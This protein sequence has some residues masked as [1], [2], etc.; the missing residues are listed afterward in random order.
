MKYFEKYPEITALLKGADHVDVKIVEG[1]ASLREFI[2]AMLSYYPWWIVSLYYVRAVFVRLLGMRQPGRPDEL[3]RLKPEDISMT[4][5][6]H[7]AFFIVHLAREEEYWIAETPEDKHLQAHFGIVVEPVN[8]NLNRFHVVT[9][10]HYKHWTG[11][12]Y[13]NTIRPFHHLVVRRM[14]RAGATPS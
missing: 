14:A 8:H 4:A 9:I 11:P 13:F 3:P 12:V 10:V 2:A 7:A 1:H 5:G 6:E